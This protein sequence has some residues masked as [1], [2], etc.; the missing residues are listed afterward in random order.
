[1]TIIEDRSGSS[2]DAGTD[3]FTEGVLLARLEAMVP[4]LR[5]RAA[6]TEQLRRL[7]DE[8]ITEAL[9]TGFIGAFR[10]QRYG[11]SGLGLSALANGTRILAHGCA[12]S[13]WTLVFLAQHVWMIGKMP[14]AM[15]ET[16]LGAGDI[17]LIASALAASGTATPVEG[18]YLLTGTS[19]WNSAIA[20]SQ[21]TSIKAMLNDEVHSFYLPVREV[22]LDDGW[23]TSGMRGTS[24]DSFVAKDVFVPESLVMPL[25]ALA[26][27][28][29]T[30]PDEPFIDYPY[31][32]TVAITCSAVV[33]GA[34]EA[35]VDLFEEKM[36]SRVLAFSGNQQQ[37]EQPFAQMRLG[38]ADL[39][40]RMARELWDGCIRDMDGWC[41]DGGT[42][43]PEQRVGIR[44]RCALM[45]RVCRE[46]VG[47]IMNAA[48]GSSYFLSAPLQRI[49]RDVEVLKSHAIF[50]WD[51]T[52]QLQGRLRLGMSPAPTDLV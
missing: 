44:A 50:D 31:I 30:H 51:R 26:A 24:S 33:L 52:A 43:T 18:G 40:M 1:M 22:R 21:W 42:M 20:H 3:G 11:G 47:S 15:Q 41:G 9:E 8:T 13:A 2:A 29:E 10:P 48:G 34:A 5:D 46:L 36:R 45:V 25:R 38:E 28:I 19:E 27:S 49:Q 35:A 4:R 37:V 6:E 39:H 16:F 14:P 32:A 7:P 12:S 23:H 17:P